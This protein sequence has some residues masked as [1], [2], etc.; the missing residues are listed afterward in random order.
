MKYIIRYIDTNGNYCIDTHLCT[1]D[2]WEYVVNFERLPY[3]RE[4]LS[5]ES[6]Y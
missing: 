6:R 3:V 1:G 2:I 5:V 4:V